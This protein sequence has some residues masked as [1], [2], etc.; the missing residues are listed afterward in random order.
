MREVSGSSLRIAAGT[1]LVLWM[2]L[3][4]PAIIALVTTSYGRSGLFISLLLMGIATVLPRPSKWF[5]AAILRPSTSVFV[6]GI[7]LLSAAI[8]GWFVIVMLGH[9]VLALDCSVYLLQARAM[10][11][12]SLGIPQTLPGSYQSSRF[13]FEGPD[14]LFY[15]VFPP[16]YPLFLM[17]FELLRMPMLSGPITAAGL[18][19]AQYFLAREIGEEEWVARASLLLPL[20]CY[21]RAIETAD[22]L[23][24][25]FLA[26]L[27]TI[28][29]IAAL[30]CRTQPQARWGI[31]L[32]VCAGW[33]FSARLLDGLVLAALLFGIGIWLGWATRDRKLWAVALAAILSAAPFGGL[34]LFQQKTATGRWFQPT[35]SEF[36]QRSDY[37]PTCHRLGF[38]PDVG[39]KI[40]HP[41]ERAS[42]GAD[43]YTLDDALR[44]GSE[45]ATV[46]GHDII[47]FAPLLLLG[48]VSLLL[49]PSME[50]L[51]LAVWWVGLSF[52]Y[53]L[54]YYGNAPAYGARHLFPVVPVVYLLIARV[55][56]ALAKQSQKHL[57]LKH[58]LGGMLLVL[59]TLSSLTQMERW[60]RSKWSVKQHQADRANIYELAS[61]THD[62][63][64]VSS[65]HFGLIAAIDPWKNRGL[66]Q[67]G[68]DDHAGLIEL[69]RAHPSWKAF[70]TTPNGLIPLDL[71]AI[72]P[73]LQIE[74]EQAW[75]SR[76]WPDGLA[77]RRVETEKNLKIESS[78]GEALGIHVAVINKTA[79]IAFDIIDPGTFRLSLH[80]FAG[81]YMGRYEIELD[82]QPHFVWEGYSPRLEPRT[83]E[84]TPPILLERGPHRLRFR[85][86]G[87]APES[88]G[89][90]GLFD[91]LVG[92]PAPVNPDALPR[93]QRP[94]TNLQLYLFS[95]YLYENP[96]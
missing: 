45:R 78:G 2:L 34:V 59:L 83:S 26:L 62:A 74:L 88:E 52:A 14:G 30:K 38:G 49:A 21:A 87:R 33:G 27:A 40:E 94:L 29:L 75:P 57:D 95:S 92:E 5:Q 44:V 9:K 8:S 18:V 69:R 15:G 39:C 73:G 1:L 11:H 54:F 58:F 17:P 25:A 35:Q 46:L 72:Q 65:D 16:G 56:P 36:F 91:T 41:P 68:H 28:A 51:W 66:R 42:F 84:P 43:G 4:Y 53:L 67:V 20:P 19:V 86:V 60:R 93:L 24:H 32:G 47:G 79:E 76:V 55:L 61:Q 48:F 10:A 85:C 71:P 22:L 31:L 64:I 7:A 89:L 37:P 3:F 6:G 70:S 90:F 82:G 63:I 81:P 80:G 96:G 12:G 50:A 13:L 77:L 23:S